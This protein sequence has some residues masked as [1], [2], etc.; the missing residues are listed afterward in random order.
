MSVP[1]VSVVMSVYNA[2]KFLKESIDSI[3]GQTFKN[4][5]FIIVNDASSDNSLT[6]IESYHDSRIV[7]INNKRNMG[8]TKSL[9]SAIGFAKG[10]YIARMD[11]D[12]IALP[13]RLEKQAKMFEDD[14]ELVLLG[15]EVELITKEGI[16]FGSRGHETE[17]AAIRV[18][19]LQG[20][21]GALTHPVVMFRVDKFHEIGGYDELFT[22]VE[23]LDLFLR[24]S[25]K[26]RVINLPDTLLCW[27][28]HENS[29]NHTKF[30]KWADQKALV[31]R[32]TIKRIGVDA[33]LSQLF[34]SDFQ[35][36]P[37]YDY[38]DCT[39]IALKNGRFS[40]ARRLLIKEIRN[41]GV[42]MLSLKLLIKSLIRQIRSAL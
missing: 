16:S 32:K 3:L 34:V 22:V 4:F 14:P 40:S 2:E 12:D 41:N 1:L 9:N 19:L 5:E 33:Y 38:I 27:R 7:L 30:S 18:Q 10:R 13:Q 21:G 37:K 17:P 28:Q 20:N 15:A 35:K 8:L 11:A 6:I 25:E 39:R 36:M 26:G 24:L 42:S 31:I 23:D 29:I